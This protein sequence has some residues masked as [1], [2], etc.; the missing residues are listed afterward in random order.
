[1]VIV[2]RVIMP[3]T[4]KTY[5]YKMHIIFTF[6]CFSPLLVVVLGDAGNSAGVK[7]EKMNIEE[8]VCSF[9]RSKELYRL[10]LIN[11]TTAFLWLKWSKLNPQNDAH[12]SYRRN[13]HDRN[14]D[15]QIAAFS[16][17]E[18]LILLPEPYSLDKRSGGIG[19]SSWGNPIYYQ[20]SIFD[21]ITY[22]GKTAAEVCATALIDIIKIEKIKVSDIDQVS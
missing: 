21:T 6:S 10:G 16:L 1:M 13:G 4:Y 20:L 5:L 17:A 3:Q 19:L 9:E 14:F 11:E 12:I 18:L 7:C 2:V 8:Q 15:I 22:F